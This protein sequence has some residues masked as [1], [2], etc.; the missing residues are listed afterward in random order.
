MYQT[1]REKIVGS[2]GHEAVTVSR[3]AFQRKEGF[4][5]FNAWPTYREAPGQMALAGSMESE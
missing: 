1:D 4:M 5:F 3:E 2:E